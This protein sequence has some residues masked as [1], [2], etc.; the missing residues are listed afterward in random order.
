M[1]KTVRQLKREM[2]LPEFNAWRAFSQV[3]PI[4]EYRED[5]RMAILNNTIARCA[6]AKTQPKDFVIDWWAPPE[7]PEEK[8]KRLETIILAFARTH[9]KTV[10]A[11]GRKV[12][13]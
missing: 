8:A 3:E 12:R 1:G 7:D 11:R 9:N 6:G 10:E 5:L 2:E 4:G 13:G